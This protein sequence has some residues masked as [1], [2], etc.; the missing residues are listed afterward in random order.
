MIGR[1]DQKIEIERATTAPDGGGGQLTTWAP[2]AVDPEP[3]ARVELKGGS[4][5]ITQ[6]RQRA[7]FTVRARSDLKTGDRIKWGGMIWNIHA[8]GRP[9]ARAMY[10]T[11]EASTGELSA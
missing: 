3:F 6:A 11:I 9:V 4:E 1:L 8:L 5:A 7:A 2:L 10:Q